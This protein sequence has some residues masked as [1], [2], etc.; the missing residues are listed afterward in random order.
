MY[1]Y[2][3][4]RQLESDI[5]DTKSQLYTKVIPGIEINSIRVVTTEE[6]FQEI[7]KD[8][9]ERLTEAAI[10]QGQEVNPELKDATINNL[11]FANIQVFF[12][13]VKPEDQ[14]EDAVIVP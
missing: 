12:E 9:K 3:S 13:R 2:F 6:V 1:K 10:A 14:V 5:L 7:Q 11:N 8:V 4:L